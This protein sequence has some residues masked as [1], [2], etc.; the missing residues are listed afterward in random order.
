MGRMAGNRLHVR[1]PGCEAELVVDAATGE[2]LSHR[3][4]KRAPAG[5][6]DFD[7]LLKGLDESKA[8]AE[9]LFEQEKAA[10]KDRQRLLDEKFAEAMKRAEEE[11]DAGPP[12]RPFDFD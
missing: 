5:G 7:S 2:V 6:K 10:M 8:R 9:A 1:C 12:R 11:P 4:P 3:E